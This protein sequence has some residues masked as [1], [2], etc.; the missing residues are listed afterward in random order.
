MTDAFT[1]KHYTL[2][3]QWVKDLPSYRFPLTRDD[4]AEELSKLFATDSEKFSPVRFF[5]AVRKE[6]K[7]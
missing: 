1:H 5:T 6:T 4:L 2:C 3:A 7:P